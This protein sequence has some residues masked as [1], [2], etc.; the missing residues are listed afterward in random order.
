LFGLFKKKNASE[1][2]SFFPIQSDM[3]S[4]I[5]PGI[6]DGSQDIGSSIILVKGMLALGITKAVATPHIIG[7]MYRNNSETINAALDLLRTALQ[8]EQIQFEVSAAAEY[9][10]DSYFFELLTN[11]V[12]ILTIKDNLILT[13]FSYSSM[14]SNPEQMAFTILTEGYTPIL[15]HPERYAYY[16]NNFK[17]YDHLKELGYLL[18]VNLLSLTGYYGKET[19]KA[20]R[21]IIKNGLVSFAG[22]DMHHERHL[23]ALSDNRNRKLFAEVFEEEMLLNGNL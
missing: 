14:P 10:L 6:D 4:H 7:D 2:E 5:L 9:M 12:P 18:Q 19:A 17:I 8:K 15:A 16:H 22:T 20:A 3:H 13:E 11:K 23:A 21:Y 1:T